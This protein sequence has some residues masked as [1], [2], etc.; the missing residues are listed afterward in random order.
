MSY[1]T[2]LCRFDTTGNE[3]Q[4]PSDGS[5]AVEPPWAHAHPKVAAFFS[6]KFS[7]ALDLKMKWLCD[8][9]P[10]MTKQKIV[11]DATEAY[12]DQL[13]AEHYKEA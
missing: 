11:Q 1:H 4:K 13:I 12:V 6:T 8:N 9:V 2:L 5:E 7:E 10:R 3:N